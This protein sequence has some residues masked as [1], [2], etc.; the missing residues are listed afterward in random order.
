[1]AKFIFILG[2]ARSGKSRY[3]IELA[4]SLSRKVA[5][6]ATCTNPDQEMTE[7]IRL[8][9]KSRPRHWRVVEENKDIS[10]ALHKLKN[11][12][13]VVII[14]CLG[15]LVSNLLSDELKDDEIFKNVKKLVQGI[16][17]NRATIILVSNEVGSG[18]VPENLL[19]RR[20][21]DLLGLVNQMMAQKA[22]Q[23]ILMQ[24]GIPLEIKN[25]KCKVQ[26]LKEK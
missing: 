1:M 12:Y 22:D 9:K 17:N 4:K 8:H 7:R 6:V 10:S 2:G 19:A 25:A 26:D 15:L 23:A 3:A 13:D 18:I 16:S 20:F 11:K 14:D 21:R 5:Y 24:A